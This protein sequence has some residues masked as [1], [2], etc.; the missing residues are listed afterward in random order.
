[1]KLVNL[2]AQVD[3]GKCVGCKTCE[4]VC[5]VLAIKVVDGK[6]EVD[7]DRCRGCAACEQRCPVYA[8]SMQKRD[9]PLLVSVDIASVNYDE[10]LKLCS[11]AL[12]HPEQVV[13]YCTGTRAE[14]IAAAILKGAK[15][16]EDISFMTGARTGC[17][18]ECIQPI[19]RLL[20]AAGVKSTPPQGGWQWYGRTVT[21]WEI[22]KKVREKH[23]SR[24]FY[25]DEDEKLLDR[26]RTAPLQGRGV[27]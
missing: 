17:K 8:I 14:E 9:N 1:M 16:P 3:R 10:I 27:K 24:G 20:E 7:V 5:P 4:K 22:P 2:I 26:V 18:V 21:V 13:C 12:L 15:S 19:L 11:N 25:F 23:S 6:A